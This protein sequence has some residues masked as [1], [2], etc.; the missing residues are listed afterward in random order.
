MTQSSPL[1]TRG[2]P[3]LSIPRSNGTPPTAGERGLMDRYYD[4]LTSAMGDDEGSPEEEPWENSEE[5]SDPEE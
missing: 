2:A 1:G 4:Q 3:A 5:Y